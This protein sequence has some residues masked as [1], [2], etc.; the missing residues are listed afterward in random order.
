V[1]GT[2]SE[3]SGL[4]GYS[5]N[6]D[7]EWVIAPYGAA[8]VM[9]H[10]TEFKTQ[11]IQDVVSIYQCQDASCKEQILLLAQLSGTYPKAQTIT[12]TT[13]YMKVAFRSDSNTNAEGFTAE[14]SSVLLET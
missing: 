12:S 9:L 5:N 11:A 13:G 7:C 6:A 8:Q 10:F 3:G 2:L 1:N 4:S 14:W